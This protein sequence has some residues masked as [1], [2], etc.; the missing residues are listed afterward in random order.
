MSYILILTSFRTVFFINYASRMV[1][2]YIAI[3]VGL[4]LE[5]MANDHPSGV[6]DA[7]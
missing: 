7:E 3:P 2:E 6:I 1:R 5:F 4:L